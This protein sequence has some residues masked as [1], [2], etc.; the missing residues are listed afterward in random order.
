MTGEW[1]L[2][3]EKIEQNQIDSDVFQRKLKPMQFLLLKNFLILP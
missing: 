1:E 2:A 3:L